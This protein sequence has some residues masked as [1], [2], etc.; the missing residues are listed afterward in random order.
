MTPSHRVPVAREIRVLASPRAAELQQ[1]VASLR[2]FIGAH[3]RP[4][5]ACGSAN[6]CHTSAQL[7][8]SVVQPATSYR[9]TTYPHHDGA[10]FQKKIKITLRVVIVTWAWSER[11][12]LTHLVLTQ[13][14]DIHP[15]RMPFSYRASTAER[16]AA[17]QPLPQ[18]ISTRR[19][20][21][22][23]APKLLSVAAS[24]AHPLHASVCASRRRCRRHAV[25]S[26]F[27]SRQPIL[28]L[29]LPCTS[30]M[31]ALRVIKCAVGPLLCTPSFGTRLAAC[32]HGSTNRT[33]LKKHVLLSR[34]LLPIYSLVYNGGV[35]LFI[36]FLFILVK[37]LCSNPGWSFAL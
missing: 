32:W 20:P 2:P 27:S 36:I 16:N 34:A 4:P 11:A 12:Q 13:P 6:C 18:S 15:Q 29:H 26:S 28:T 22:N 23:P 19:Q 25:P 3:R 7:A 5:V 37:G 35:V 9:S 10:G 21:A 8:A 17:A 33:A 1:R 30:A 24:P 31:S 14:R